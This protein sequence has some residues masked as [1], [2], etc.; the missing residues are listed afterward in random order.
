MFD[1]WPCDGVQVILC[2]AHEVPADDDWLGPREREVLAGL[3][4]ARRPSWRL[5]RFTAKRALDDPRIEV[6]AEASGQ[7]R[8]WLG[9]EPIA[10]PISISH[11]QGLCAVAVGQSG[12]RLGCDLEWL[13][14]RSDAMVADF[15][16]PDEVRRV[17]A[18][19]DRQLVANL[20]WTAK[21]AALKVD[22]EGLRRDTRSVEVVSLAGLSL[23]GLSGEG[24]VV[25]VRDH[26][27]GSYLDGRWRRIR[28]WVLTVVV[29]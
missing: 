13:E 23:E 22:G 5:G 14:P 15:F 7:P 2:E 16:C 6:L 18:A 20:V 9:A 1:D 19:E 11:R 29:G 3:H 17:A 4:R 27:V 28:G 24:G 8:A 21:E 26:L 10:R 25:R 12:Q